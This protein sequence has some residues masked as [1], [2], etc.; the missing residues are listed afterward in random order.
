MA[1]ERILV[2]DDERGVRALCSDLL[3]RAGYE[4]EAVDSGPAALARFA[5]AEF[6]AVLADVNMPRM[7]GIEL[8]RRLRQ[9]RPDQIVVLITGFPSI[10]NAVRGMKEGAVDYVT[11]PFTPD[12]LRLVVAR[13]LEERELREENERLRRDL[14][15]RHGLDSIVGVSPGM[16][17]LFD[18]ARKVA[19]TDTTVLIEGESGTGKE[20]FAR[21]LHVHS[22]RAT[23]TFVAVNCGSLVSTLLESELFGHVKGAFTGAHASKVGLFQAAS[24]GTIFLDEIGELALDLQPKLLRVLQE[25]E[26][27]PVGGVES[28]KVDVRVIAATNRDL[29]QDLRAGRFREDLY[30]RLNVICLKVPPL[31]ERRDDIP[32]LVDRFL[33]TYAQKARREIDGVTHAALDHLQAQPWPGNVRELQNAVERAIILSSGRV[34]DVADLAQGPAVAL[35]APEPARG[36]AA[37]APAPYPFQAMSLEEVERRHIEHVM[38]AVGGQKTRAAEILGINRTTLWKKLRQYDGEPD[39]SSGEPADD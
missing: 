19:P 31:R 28:R 29:A 7:D 14:R 12:E 35:R 21:A 26:L 20:L 32:L 11:K 34:I 6:D 24:G 10:E 39:G 30:Y 15:Q 2:V 3:K 5:E 38:Q 22:R 33:R 23:R 27:K 9:E 4:V 25:G 17:L 37:A 1:H 16:Q 8:C 36:A 13:A 18:T